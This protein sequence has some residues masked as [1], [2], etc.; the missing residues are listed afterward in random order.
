M[1]MTIR[2]AKPANRQTNSSGYEHLSPDIVYHCCHLQ[3][4]QLRAIIGRS[5]ACFPCQTLCHW[6][7][8]LPQHRTGQQLSSLL[9]QSTDGS[10]QPFHH[11][12]NR[13]IG[14]RSGNKCQ[15]C[16][17][18]A[19]PLDWAPGETANLLNMFHSQ[20]RRDGWCQLQHR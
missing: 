18:G 6:H 20:R 12:R 15:R 9:Q 3:A 17:S 1:N 11:T 4:S 7:R 19:E 5:A 14:F 2:T 16:L 8:S 10:S 13:A